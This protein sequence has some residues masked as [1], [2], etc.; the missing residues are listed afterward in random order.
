MSKENFGSLVPGQFFFH[1]GKLWVKLPDLV[2]NGVRFNAVRPAS[3]D[4]E[5]EV[6]DEVT[7]CEMPADIFVEIHIGENQEMINGFMSRLNT[8]KQ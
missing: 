7:T 5:P 8:L 4:D 3:G 2:H 1:D 6:K